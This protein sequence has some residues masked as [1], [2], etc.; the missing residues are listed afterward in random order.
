MNLQLRLEN[1]LN[2]LQI[3]INSNDQKLLIEEILHCNTAG[4]TVPY[5]YSSSPTYS[6]YAIPPEDILNFIN[7]SKEEQT[8]GEYIKHLVD[9]KGISKDSY[10]YNKVGISRD[11]WCRLT[12]DTIKDPSKQKLYAISVALELT[13]PEVIILLEK[14]GYAF[15]PSCLFDTAFVLIFK[16][17]LYEPFEIDNI[18]V[19][20]LKLDPVFSVA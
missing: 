12:N 4:Y 11:Y 2:E 13:L 7:N 8:L 19:N 9:S 6:D 5:T 3:I 1:L 14:A 16:N 18:L 17:M 20:V 10:V 15:K